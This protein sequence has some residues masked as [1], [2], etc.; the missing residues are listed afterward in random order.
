MTSVSLDP[1]RNDEGRRSGDQLA[2]RCSS[3]HRLAAYCVACSFLHLTLTDG[4]RMH[5]MHAPALT[6]I[7]L[8][9]LT[10]S[11]AG[12]SA[13]DWVAARPAGRASHG[14]Y[15]ATAKPQIELCPS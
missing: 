6:H 2:S 14:E 11:S 7:S 8:L 3:A 1:W 13:W 9:L 15:E 10:R 12:S 4:R 5:G